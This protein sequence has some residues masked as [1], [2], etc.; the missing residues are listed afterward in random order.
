[1]SKR[2]ETARR[3][4]KKINTEQAWSK[5][6]K[7]RNKLKSLIKSKYLNYINDLSNSTSNKSKRFWGVIKNKTKSRFI[8]ETIYYKD[9]HSSNPKDKANLFNEFF[10]NNFTTRENGSVLPEV[11]EILNPEL[12]EIQVSVAEVR[13]ALNSLDISKATGPD[14]LSGRIL[15][16]CASALAPSLTKLFNKSLKSGIVPDIWKLA[17]VAPVHKKDKKD[18]TENYRPISLL[19]LTSKILERCIFNNIYPKIKHLITLLQHGFL[20]GKSTS[21]QLLSFLN[22]IISNIDADLQTD[23][24]YLDYAKAFDSVSHKLLI[25][26]LKSF[27][28]SGP[29]LYWFNNYLSNRL[30]RVV[31]EGSSSDWLPVHS[32]VPQGSILGPLLFLLYINDIADVISP[33][34]SLALF[35]DDSKVFRNVQSRADSLNLQSDLDHIVSWSNKWQL[36]FNATKCKCLTINNRDPN[37]LFNY[38]INNTVLERVNDIKDLGLTVTSALSWTKHIE[39]KIS[40]ADKMLGL[41]KR[42]IGYRCPLKTK[43]NLYN[44]MVKTSL[45]Y[46]SIIWSYGTKKNLKLVE[47]VQRRATKYISNNYTLDYKSRLKICNLLPFSYTKEIYDICF[48]YKCIHNFYN[49]NINNYLNFYDASTSRTRFGQRPYTI[50][51]P[52]RGRTRVKDFYSKRILKIWNDLPADIVNIIPSNNLI[53]PFK[54][55]VRE[56]YKNKLD[57]VFNLYDTCTWRTFCPCGR[58]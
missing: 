11:E 4:A 29:L 8:P 19:C 56:H 45:S 14:K 50:K 41:I 26:K 32:G 34:S 22:N 35:A 57:N 48:L 42:T 53:L 17:N 31:L 13:L 52:P 46:G 43:L 2:K 18:N 44:A 25:I 1:M 3:R 10:Y 24:I 40:K 20:K 30:Q 39:T 9:K 54:R 23:I 33:G 51:A 27:G 55:R 47:A 58:C 49:I 37:L 36:R 21:T 5:Y 6:N 28:F 38:T 12:R 7:L 16:E 15:K